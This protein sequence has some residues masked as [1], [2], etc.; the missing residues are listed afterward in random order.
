MMTEF[1]DQVSSE[2]K[3]LAQPLVSICVPTYNTEKT[4]VST[5]HSILGQTY[6]NLE[7]LVV[8][9]AS[10]DNTLALLQQFNDPRI[11]IHQNE[12]NIGAEANF[13]KGIRLSTGEYIAI[14]H[15]DDLYLPNIVEKQVRALQKNPSA[16]AVFTLARCINDRGEPI[17][18]GRLPVKLR[19]K[20]IYHFSEIFIHMLED[21]NFL[22][23]PSCMVR[24]KL[25]KKLMPFDAVSF[26]VHADFDMW[27]RILEKSPIVILEE[28]LMCYRIS[29]ERGS[30]PYRYSRTEQATFFKVMDYHLSFKSDI[31]N[32]PNNTLGKY[33]FQKSLDRITRAVNCL[34][35]DRPEEA[36]KLLK[37]S[38]SGAPFRAVVGGFRNPKL[39]AFW[40]FGIVLLGLVYLSLG[41]YQG[42]GLHWLL[43]RRGR[44]AI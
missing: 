11:V 24:G 27:L 23:S 34:V 42:E 3:V 33:K 10:T 2:N 18:K 21:G 14:F 15:A 32:I 29:N 7:I 41:R 5:L 44:K 38:L 16:G 43:Y 19:G 40:I 37:Q 22:M 20:G 8:D 26:G 25:Y 12:R 9:N 36:K 31:L 17:R 4:V 1:K 39:L 13:S 30:Y 28:E 35:K 6:R